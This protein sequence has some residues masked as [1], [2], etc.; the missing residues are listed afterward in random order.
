MQPPAKQH[1]A[2]T[3]LLTVHGA[4]HAWAI[5]SSAVAAVEALAD[6]GGASVPLDVLALLGETP[7]VTSHASRVVVLRV[8]G[9]ELRLLVDGVLTLTETK[10]SNLLPL[11]PAVQSATRLVSHIA[12]L[13]GKPALFVLSPERLL[14]VAHVEDVNA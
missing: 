2:A 13:D 7:T 9:E 6:T 1:P 10:S 12:V 8:Q 11:P 5:P 4:G 14:E 3:A